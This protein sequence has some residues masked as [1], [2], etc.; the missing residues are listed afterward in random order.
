MTSHEYNLGH[1]VLEG[2]IKMQDRNSRLCLR[3]VSID[4]Y[5]DDV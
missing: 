5:L 2:G 3:P 4:Y 1:W